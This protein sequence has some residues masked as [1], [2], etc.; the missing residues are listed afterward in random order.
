MMR[1]FEACQAFLH[2]GN[3]QTSR[4]GMG[5]MWKAGA[6]PRVHRP[7]PGCSEKIYK[8]FTWLQLGFSGWIRRQSGRIA[9]IARNPV[10]TPFICCFSPCCMAPRML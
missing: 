10:W 3:R 5:I 2:D 4:A 8:N 1:I 6:W 7:H 9:V